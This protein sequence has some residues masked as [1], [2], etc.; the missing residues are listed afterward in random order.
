MERKIKNQ[1]AY[2]ELITLNETVKQSIA[3]N[4]LPIDLFTG[5]QLVDSK[6]FLKDILKG[7]KGCFRRAINL[8]DGI[9]GW[10]IDIDW[11]ATISSV[12]FNQTFSGRFEMCFVD[13]GLRHLIRDMS[14]VCEEDGYLDSSD[15]DYLRQLEQVVERAH[16]EIRFITEFEVE[17]EAELLAAISSTIYTAKQQLLELFGDV[18]KK[19]YHKQDEQNQ[20]VPN[21]IQAALCQ[22]PYN[23][24]QVDRSKSLAD[25]NVG[26][27][28]EDEDFIGDVLKKVW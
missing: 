25:I 12:Y 11:H 17:T 15:R 24:V 16:R 6:Y 4:K 14:E 9:G 5:I 13:F 20:T 10:E 23:I 7:H 19:P 18:T 27:I 26:R 3:K 2:N 28:D 1:D 22:M 21:L 8:S